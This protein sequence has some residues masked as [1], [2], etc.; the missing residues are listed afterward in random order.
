MRNWQVLSAERRTTHC[1]IA[2]T[3]RD[4]FTGGG[5]LAEPAIQLDL[6]AGTSWKPSSTPPIRTSGGNY[7]WPGLGRSSAPLIA[8]LARVRVRIEL[9]HQIAFYRATDDGLEFDVPPYNDAHP[10]AVS[11]VMP[12]VVLL[13]PGPSYPFSRN[14]RVLRGHV[15]DIGGFPV[16]DAVVVADGVE[17]AMTDPH[18]SFSLPLR[19]Q[20]LSG[21]VAVTVSHPRSG[22][23]AGISANLPADLASSFDITVS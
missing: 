8:P 3:L 1:P 22:A 19:W 15:L 6:Q 18:G 7:I 13:L 10:P 17:R 12:Q 20:P 14:V 21:P 11:P 2:L 9:A 23:G 4:E 5:A 16:R